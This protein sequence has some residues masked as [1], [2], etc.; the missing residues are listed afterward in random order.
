[1]SRRNFSIFNFT[2]LDWMVGFLGCVI[3]QLLLAQKGIEQRPCPSIH[4][5]ASN[6]HIDTASKVIYSMLDAETIRRLQIGDSMILVAVDFKM[7]PSDTI[8][9]NPTVVYPPGKGG[10][11]KPIDTT[12]PPPKDTISPPKPIIYP[13]VDGYINF[14][15]K[16]ESADDDFRLL[17]QHNKDLL[18]DKKSAGFFRKNKIVHSTIKFSD[19]NR[20][21]KHY[22]FGEKV[23][24]L[25]K[26]VP[27]TYQIYVQ[28]R[29]HKKD[30]NKK[31]EI[32]KLYC[33]S[34][35]K[36]TSNRV[37]EIRI[38]KSKN[39]KERILVKTVTVLEDGTIIYK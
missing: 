9:I 2:F 13:S 10:S 39:E 3:I 22:Y 37:F 26:V 11:G 14:V 30:K 6:A 7:L 28:Y 27:G 29:G 21:L 31:E 4:F 38:P 23:T 25:N 18:A 36:A 8:F 34:K 16:H 1:M 20:I 19:P 32:A 17:V 24:Q 33:M 5:I 12:I 15:I 35:E